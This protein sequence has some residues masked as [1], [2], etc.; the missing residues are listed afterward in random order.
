MIDLKAG[1]WRKAMGNAQLASANDLVAQTLARHGLASPLPS[2]TAAPLSPRP[3]GE[4]GGGTIASALAGLAGRMGRPAA[5]PDPLPDGAS[6]A[7]DSFTCPAG[8]RR[9]RTYVPASAKDGVTG[10]VVMLH[11]CTQNPEDFAAGTGMNQLAEAHRFIV[12]YPAQS[13][14]DNA[15]SCWNWFSRGD[16]RRD[17][18]EPAIIAGITRSVM[19]RHAVPPQQVF[20]AGLS[21]GA[22]MAVILGAAYPELF[23]AVGAHSGLP[24]GAAK[25]VPSAFAAMAG[26][27][28][29]AGSGGPAVRTIV[30][31]GSADA[32]V[33]PQNGERIARHAIDNGPRESLQTKSSGSAGGRS[34]RRCVTHG[35]GTGGG[36][37]GGAPSVEHWLIDGMGHA[38]SGGKP[39]GS[40]TDPKGPDASAEMVR[41]FFG[42]A[43]R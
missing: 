23:H 36:D 4:A 15:Q 28:T 10:L 3:L 39:A 38:W 8:T 22:A 41:F 35:E 16:Q 29:D 9:Y 12:V 7:E 24:L 2:G 20:V 25:D 5:A 40:Y 19:E 26:Q 30:F 17:R 13:R 31:H 43:P 21:A 33:H 37:T 18:G 27:V 14:G 1:A 6:F 11:G 34:Y 42:E 32:T